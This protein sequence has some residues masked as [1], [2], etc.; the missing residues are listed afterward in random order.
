MILHIC[1]AIMDTDMWYAM[2]DLLSQ[3][4]ITLKG[5]VYKQSS[6]EIINI[7]RWIDYGGSYY[8]TGLC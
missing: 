3:L 7:E 4:P 1:D 6:I 8:D 5:L 2:E